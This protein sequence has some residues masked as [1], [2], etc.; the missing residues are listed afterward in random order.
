MSCIHPPDCVFT[1]LASK[2]SCAVTSSI[3]RRRW[4][5][6]GGPS[7]SPICVVASAHVSRWRCYTLSYP[8]MVCRF[9]I[10]S[11]CASRQWCTSPRNYTREGLHYLGDL[12]RPVGG[13]ARPH[14]QRV[15][16]WSQFT[17]HSLIS[18]WPV[19]DSKLI[20]FYGADVPSGRWIL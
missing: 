8:T 11:T 16:C 4:D 10:F 18:Q 9:P 14:E 19:S 7:S 20:Y 2:P 13:Q 17:S 12:G 1:I 3:W 5:G 15:Q 6:S